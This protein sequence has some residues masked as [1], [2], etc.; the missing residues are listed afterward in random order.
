MIFTMRI[1]TFMVTLI[2]DFVTDG[3]ILPFFTFLEV[4]MENI[5]KLTSRKSQESIISQEG[6]AKQFLYW[7]TILSGMAFVVYAVIR[8]VKLFLPN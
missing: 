4:L 1:V 6:P 3:P 8:A 5:S 7:F 2:T